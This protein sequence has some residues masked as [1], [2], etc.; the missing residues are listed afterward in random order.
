MSE[1]ESKIIHSADIM[2]FYRCV[3]FHAKNT[4]VIH[5]SVRGGEIPPLF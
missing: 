3:A 5:L 2:Q 1:L 4:S